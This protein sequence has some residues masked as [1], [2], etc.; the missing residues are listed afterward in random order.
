MDAAR[1][2]VDGKIPTS[3]AFSSLI[4]FGNNVLNCLSFP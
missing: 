1:N 3:L 2:V 4:S